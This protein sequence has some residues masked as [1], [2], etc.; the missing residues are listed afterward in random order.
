[1]KIQQWILEGLYPD[2]AENPMVQRSMNYHTASN[3][4]FISPRLQIQRINQ[5]SAIRCLL[6]TPMRSRASSA[7]SSHLRKSCEARR[8]RRYAS[9]SQEN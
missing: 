2:T 1:M 4:A 3:S 6:S 9:K 8:C 5:G 7:P